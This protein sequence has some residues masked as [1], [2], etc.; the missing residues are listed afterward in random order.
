M[1]V[2]VGNVRYVTAL[3]DTASRYCD[4]DL[5]LSVLATGVTSLHCV[6][7]DHV[8]LVWIFEAVFATHFSSVPCERWVCGSDCLS[9]TDSETASTTLC[10]V[11]FKE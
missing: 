3:S 6:K 11:T 10:C 8:F 9:G 5:C 7:L 2:S 4:L 1:F